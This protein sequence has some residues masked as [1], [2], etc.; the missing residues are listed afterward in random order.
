MCLRMYIV[1]QKEVDY[2]HIYFFLLSCVNSTLQS[3]WAYE[4][5]K[6]SE[7]HNR[8]NRNGNG[9]KKNCCTTL[10][11]CR[12]ELTCTEPCRSAGVKLPSVAPGFGTS[13]HAATPPLAF[14][15][16]WSD[17]DGG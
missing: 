1:D 15:C 17:G 3:D 8:N 11:G 2:Y 6:A 4:K 7:R 13:G 9:K 14:C 5:E 16:G 12:C 10:V